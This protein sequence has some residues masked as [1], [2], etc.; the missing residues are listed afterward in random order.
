MADGNNGW[1]GIGFAP[2]EE[3]T[4]YTADICAEVV[5]SIARGYTVGW[6]QRLIGS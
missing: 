3:P 5:T 6:L 1:C 4:V 2:G